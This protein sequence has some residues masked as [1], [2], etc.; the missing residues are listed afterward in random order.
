M[1]I[2]VVDDDP[3]IRNALEVILGALGHE[4]TLAED[5]EKGWLAFSR[6]EFQA[7]I[8]DWVMPGIEGPDLCQMIRGQS[9]ER[10]TYVIMLTALQG[11]SKYIEALDSGADDFISKPLNADELAARLR[12]AQ[13]WLRVHER[14]TQLEGLLSICSDCK[15]I[16]D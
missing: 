9:R 2:L 7:V 4:V 10:Y 16:R 13:R 3:D 15:E 1:K 11:R 14:V 8:T 12:V 6:N 5:G